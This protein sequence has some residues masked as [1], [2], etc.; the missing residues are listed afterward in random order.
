MKTLKNKCSHKI[1]LP[2]VLTVFWWMMKRNHCTLDGMVQQWKFVM[3]FL[4]GQLLCSG[5]EFMSSVRYHLCVK[6]ILHLGLSNVVK[7]YLLVCALQE[8]SDSHPTCFC[9]Q[10]LWASK[11]AQA[12]PYLLF[13]GNKMKNFTI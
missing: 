6:P 1:I 3:V 7:R 5:Q 9:L 13:G 10:V 4:R 12:L 11:Q 8:H 2:L